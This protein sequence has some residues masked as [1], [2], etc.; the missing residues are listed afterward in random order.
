M[1]K[2]MQRRRHGPKRKLRDWTLPSESEDGSSSASYTV[3]GSDDR[4]N[5]SSSAKR[6]DQTRIVPH[7]KYAEEREY[8][9]VLY[10]ST[11]LC[12]VEALVEDAEYE[13]RRAE[14]LK[15]ARA[16]RG[17]SPEAHAEAS[18]ER[19]DIRSSEADMCKELPEEI[20]INSPQ[21]LP[22]LG[23]IDRDMVPGEQNF[24][25]MSSCSTYPCKYVK[26]SPELESIS[27]TLMTCCL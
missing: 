13:C 11:E 14:K 25:P 22:F 24:F 8:H 19:S 1:P 2:K 23:Q 4:E 15:N 26:N 9:K 12:A 17:R 21:I 5:P 6:Y 7:L 3:G 18:Y 27:S 16:S 10:E 20:R